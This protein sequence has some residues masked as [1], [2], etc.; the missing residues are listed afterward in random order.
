MSFWVPDKKDV[1]IRAEQVEDVGGKL[2]V[3]TEKG[4]ELEVAKKDAHP[5]NPSEF[6]KANNMADLTHLNEPLVLWH[7]QQR[8]MEQIIYTYLGLF[9]VAV[10]PYARLPLYDQRHLDLYN[11]GD[12]ENLEPHIFAVAEKAYRNMLKNGDQSVLVTGE[13]GAGKTENTKKIIQYLAGVSKEHAHKK[14]AAGESTFEDKI[15]EAN[16]ILESF[17]NAQTARNNNSLRF[18]KFIRIGFR[19]GVLAGAQIDWYLLEKSRV[20]QHDTAE[21]NYHVFYQLLAGLSP[22]KRKELCLEGSVE[23]YK[24]LVGNT[25]ITGVDDKQEFE[26]LAEA[27]QIVGF[28]ESEVDNI[29]RTLAVILHMGNVRFTLVSVDRARIEDR[30]PL[31]NLGKLAGL[32][33]SALETALLSPKVRAGK[34]MVTQHK[35]ADQARF[36]LDALAKAL[37]EKTFA[38]L[39]ERINVLLDLAA[40]AACFVGV[41]DIAGFEIFKKNSFEQLCINYTNERLQQF[42]NHHMFVLEQNEYVKENIRWNFVDYGQ[43]LQATIDLIDRNSPVGVFAALNEECIVPR[44]LDKSFVAKLSA[45]MKKDKLPKFVQLRYEN[46]FTIKHYAGDVDYDAEGWLDKNRDPL[47]QSAVALFRDAENKHI[48]SLFE[49]P[50][51]SNMRRTVAQRHKAQLSSLMAQLDSTEP[52]FVRCILPNSKKLPQILEKQLVLDQLRCNGVLEGIRIARA[53]YPNRVLFSD[54]YSRYSILSPL[55]GNSPKQGTE[56]ILSNSGLS[57]EVY[58]VGKTKVFFKNGILAILEEKREAVLNKRFLALQAYARGRLVRLKCEKALKC[59]QAAVL[60]KRNLQVYASL[61]RNEW[62]ALARRVR[63]LLATQSARKQNAEVGRFKEAAQRLEEDKKRLEQ[64][65]AALEKELAKLKENMEAERSLLDQKDAALVDA[66]A[67]TLSL[68]KRIVDEER[69]VARLKAQIE[70]L[71][72]AKSALE[73]KVASLEKSI[74]EHSKKTAVLEDQ[75]RVLGEEK[76]RLQKELAKTKTELE[77]ALRESVAQREMQVRSAQTTLSREVKK[78]ESENRDMRAELVKLKE[79]A[80]KLELA[81][82]TK[83]RDL[84]LASRSVAR[85]KEELAAMTKELAEMRTECSSLKAERDNTEKEMIKMKEEMEQ[86]E[87]RCKKLEADAAEAKS[88][89][90]LKIEDDIKFD[91]GRQKFDNEILELKHAKREVENELESER[92]RFEE[93]RQQWS[94]RNEKESSADET[95]INSSEY[96]AIRLQLNEKS[97]LLAH[98]SQERERLAQELKV[99]QT[100]LASES[101][102]NQKLTAQLRKLKRGSRFV[103]ETS[104]SNDYLK[105]GEESFQLENERLQRE[106][107]ELKAELENER[108]LSQQLEELA[109]GLQRQLRAA[110]NGVNGFRK[111][112]DFHDIYKTKYEAADAR[113]RN[114]E[115]QLRELKRAKPVQERENE[116][117][118]REPEPEM[119]DTSRVILQ[120]E[121]ATGRLRLENAQRTAEELQKLVSLYK[122]RSEEYFEKLE[123]A[124]QAVRASKRAE[125]KAKQDLQNATEQVQQLKKA[126]RSHEANVAKMQLKIN[127]LEAK[128]QSK[129]NETRKLRNTQHALT[130]ELEHYRFKLVTEKPLEAQEMQRR[131][132]EKLIV[133]TQLKK[134]IQVL[135]VRYEAE[136]AEAEE[137]SARLERQVRDMETDLERARRERKKAAVLAAQVEALQESVGRLTQEKE[138]IEGEK[139]ALEG[140][141]L[142]ALIVEQQRQ[143]IERMRRLLDGA[144]EKERQAKRELV[145]ERETVLQVVEENKGLEGLVREMQGGMRKKDEGFYERRIAELEERLS[146]GEERERALTVMERLVKDLKTRLEALEHEKQGV[147]QEK[148]EIEQERENLRLA[149]EELESREERASLGLKRVQRELEE[150]R[151]GRMRGELEGARWGRL[152]KRK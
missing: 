69:A 57:D 92:R 103:Q 31:Q 37:Y 122:Q 101:F 143:E 34:E 13:S 30:K 49:A 129:D 147:E 53:G 127:Q 26:D 9:L 75:K 5:T 99:L 41:L 105:G 17:G 4:D 18:G 45:A 42:F 111:D 115:R 117:R 112:E 46:R 7:L 81:R 21:R 35:N 134:E 79:S 64:E 142:E 58:K 124:E 128:V 116:P 102:D 109:V 66:T 20:V 6:D 1:F 126:E 23:S 130:E 39:V 104:F 94:S 86:V 67:R 12:V 148:E 95:N 145:E 118:Y 90:K 8:Y 93:E 107:S 65:K 141:I 144:L 76:G 38:H 73:K 120:E 87:A 70:D 62:Y 22:E 119:L 44:A 19:D 80:T 137:R 27:L 91:R 15:L 47:N 28:D 97:A 84:D 72:S 16:P 14:S 149:V 131:L 150:E 11:G 113:A 52:H 33:S 83:T 146:E 51:Q 106:I 24:Y 89:L 78:L 139:R 151:E 121:L 29:F 110:R 85:H 2:K 132:K 54:F 56:L 82:G 55:T 114:L 152:L 98:E 136:L 88:L 135:R 10:N 48:A 133:E 71:T 74:E 50:Q 60:I 36:A 43:D 138:L 3:R 32:D 59:A 68:E 100:R 25:S 125:K 123:E 40:S 77:K 63:P 140:G 108:R 96:N 61:K